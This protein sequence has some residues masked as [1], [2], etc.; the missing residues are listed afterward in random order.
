MKTLLTGVALATLIAMP[1]FAR[2]SLSMG[3]RGESAEAAPFSDAYAQAVPGNGQVTVYN[4]QDRIYAGDPDV[5][6]R[7]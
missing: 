6:V 1:A 7:S 5:R 4:P 2:S 3:F